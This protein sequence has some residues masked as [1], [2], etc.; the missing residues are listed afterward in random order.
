MD[1]GLKITILSLVFI[2]LLVVV[3]A[4]AMV[5]GMPEPNATAVRDQAYQAPTATSTVATTPT[6]APSPTATP[7]PTAIPTPEPIYEWDQI[8]SEYE[9]NGLLANSKYLNRGMSFIGEVYEVDYSFFGNTATGRTSAF[10]DDLPTVTLKAREFLGLYLRCGI[11]DWHQNSIDEATKIS[12]G[13][14][15]V[16]TGKVTEWSDPFL[17]LYPCSLAE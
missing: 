2:V 10:G 14:T 13:D 4:W 9:D 8:A 12:V 11:I 3:V 6:F 1:T 5:S 16:V 15:V 7:P 17:Y